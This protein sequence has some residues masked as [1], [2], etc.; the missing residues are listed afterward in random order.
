MSQMTQYK[1]YLL[2]PLMIGVF[3][4]I[5]AQKSLHVGGFVIVYIENA[6]VVFVFYTGNHNVCRTIPDCCA[7]K[8]GILVLKWHNVSLMTFCAQT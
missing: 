3:K 4:E 1:L 7:H 2:F 6:G 8:I 5:L